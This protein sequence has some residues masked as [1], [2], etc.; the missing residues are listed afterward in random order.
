MDLLGISATHGNAPTINTTAN[1]SS[2]LTAIGRTD[3]VVYPGTTHPFCR[4]EVESPLAEIHGPTGLSGTTLIPEAKA[5]IGKTNA[6]LAMRDALMKQPKGT[7]WL[8]ATG[9]L[10][11][12]ALMFAIFPEVVEHIGGLSIMGGAIGGGFTNVDTGNVKTDGDGVEERFGN[13]TPWAEF[14]VYGV[15]CF[16]SVPSVSN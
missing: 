14:N 8:V 6:I 13:E 7:A 10:T 15:D 9:S 12:P 16:T 4:K 2:V 5:P 11:N 1:T 3:V